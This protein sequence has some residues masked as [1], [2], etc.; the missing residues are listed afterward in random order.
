MKVTVK[1][2]GHLIEKA[3]FSEKEVEIS[4]GAT[5]SQL[6]ESLGIPKNFPL[7]ITLKGQG[8]PPQHLLNE[9]DRLVISHVY[10]GG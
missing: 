1:L 5:V 9:G 3:G 2:I 10:S 8:V 4:P 7:I 6:L